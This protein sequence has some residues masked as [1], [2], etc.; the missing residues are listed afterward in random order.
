MS[1]AFRRGIVRTDYARPRDPAPR[2][3][4]GRAR[5]YSSITAGLPSPWASHA[6]L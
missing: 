4:T 1:G 6:A 5:V 3:S 2:R